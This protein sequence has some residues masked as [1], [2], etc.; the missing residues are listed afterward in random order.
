M[1]VSAPAIVKKYQFSRRNDQFKVGN[2]VDR[3]NR[4]YVADIT[5]L[6]QKATRKKPA[7]P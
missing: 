4:C 1:T 2:K 7:K 3:T 5:K 6:P